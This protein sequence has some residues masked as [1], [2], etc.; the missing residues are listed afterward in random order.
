MHLQETN[1][2]R[3]FWTHDSQALRLHLTP[4]S[5]DVEDEVDGTDMVRSI[6]LGTWRIQLHQKHCKLC[7]RLCVL[8]AYGRSPSPRKTTLRRPK[9]SSCA[10]SFG[11]CCR[12]VEMAFGSKR[13][14]FCV[15]TLRACPLFVLRI[16]VSGTPRIDW[17]KRGKR[18]QAFGQARF[19]TAFE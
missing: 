15:L 10:I 9:R 19:P 2:Q 16:H 14:V 17:S 13:H 3:R 12:G 11:H 6:S 5:S 8:R 1:N 7:V 4:S 18:G